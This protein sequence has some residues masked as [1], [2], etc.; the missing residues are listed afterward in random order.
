MAY[1]SVEQ[2]NK[3]YELD[4]ATGRFYH[5]NM[6][7]SSELEAELLIDFRDKLDP[8]VFERRKST[9]RPVVRRKIISTKRPVGDYWPARKTKKMISQQ[10]ETLRMVIN[11][12]RKG[13]K[14]N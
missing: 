12:M 11:Y 5:N 8:G 1:K 4:P 13:Q 6:R 10:E 3:K 7:V 14:V 2:D 9:D